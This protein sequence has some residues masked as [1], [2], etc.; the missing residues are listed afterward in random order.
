[1]LTFQAEEPGTYRVT[2]LIS[3]IVTAARRAGSVRHPTDA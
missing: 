2:G 1:V 3:V